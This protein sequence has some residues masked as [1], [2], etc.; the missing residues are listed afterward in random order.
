MPNLFDNASEK[1]EGFD[2]SAIR[3]FTTN[4][5]LLFIEASATILYEFKDN[6]SENDCITSIHTLKNH[7]TSKIISEAYMDLD[8]LEEIFNQF[9]DFVSKEHNIIKRIDDDD[10]DETL[11]Y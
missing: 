7:I 8:Y 2:L 3:D 10:F 9:Q 4:K 11:F 5:N 1:I 6:I